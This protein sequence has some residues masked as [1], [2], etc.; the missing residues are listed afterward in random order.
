[1]FMGHYAPAMLS[2]K[3]K[4]GKPSITL[5][6]GFLAVQTI[7]FVFALL[8]I[9]GVENSV[10]S[11]GKPVFDIPWSHSLLTSLFISFIAAL[12]FKILRKDSGW[13]GFG[14]IFA[15][16]FSH[17]IMDLIVHRPDLPIYPL[18]KTVYGFGFWN[19]PWLAY[20]LEMGLLLCGFLYWI[21]R[22]TPKTK[23]YKF[24]PWG[25]FLFMGIVQFIFITLPGLQMKAGS[26]EPEYQLQGASLGVLS[27]LAFLSFAAL[28]GWVENGRVL[29]SA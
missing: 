23:F 18:D 19:Y 21:G 3:G 16:V 14:I 29:K 4:A 11:D 13:K 9:F 1:M 12:I 22:T 6:Q 28:I 10:I 5:W 24:L 26:F 25:L 27:L 17:W 2:I 20:G 8:V 15:L 7:D